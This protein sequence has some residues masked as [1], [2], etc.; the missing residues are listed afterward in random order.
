M[1]AGLP[2]SKFISAS[3]S[4]AAAAAQGIPFSSLLIVGDSNVINVKDRLRPYTSL[5]AIATD[6][7]TAAAEYLA[8]K[9][10]FAQLPQPTTVTVG[11]WAKGATSGLNLGGVLTATQQAMANWTSITA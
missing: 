3:V 11:R 5:P 9:D 1:T 10:Y 7:G 4:F 2:V 6:F 8:A